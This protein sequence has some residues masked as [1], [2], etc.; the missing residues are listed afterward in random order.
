MLANRVRCVGGPYDGEEVEGRLEEFQVATAWDIPGRSTRA[1]V[2][3]YDAAKAVYRWAGESLGDRGRDFEK[4]ADTLVYEGAWEE[5]KRPYGWAIDAYLDLGLYEEAIRTCRKL[6][7]VAPD[8]IRTRYTLAFLL[9]GKARHAEAQR[10]LADYFS[11]I[12]DHQLR[13]YAVPRLQLLAQATD[14]ADTLAILERMLQ[15]LGAEIV[16]QAAP[17]VDVSGVHPNTKWERLLFYA[18]REV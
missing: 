14:D 8:V 17:G 7:R 15:D 12:T 16:P 1:G 6:I 10:A 2:Y 3:R 4:E 5:A 11:A 9:T 18:V 13:S